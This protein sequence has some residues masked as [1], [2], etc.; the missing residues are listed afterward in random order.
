[1]SDARG[2]SFDA[3]RIVAALT[4]LLGHEWAFAKAG[5][6]PRLA[7][8]PVHTLAVMVFFS[9]SGFLIA[10]SWLRDDHLGRFLLR[11]ARRIFPALLV[12]VVLTV[13]VLGPAI[14]TLSPRA[15]FT[16]PTTW[17]YLGNAGLATSYRLPGVFAEPGR[18]SAAVNGSLWTLGL[19]FCCYLAVAAI[20]LATRR[21]GRPAS[22]AVWSVIAMLALAV[23]Q[24][25]GSHELASDGV[26]IAC[27]AFG[28]VA[29]YA[30]SVGYLPQI[31]VGLTAA[32]ILAARV[33][34]GPGTLIAC[35]AVPAT[36]IALGSRR[37][38]GFA[39]LIVA[40]D[41]SYGTYLY[42]F[43]VQQFFASSGH[44]PLS[45]QLVL[46]AC[47]TLAA[48]TLSWH[49]VERPVLHGRAPRDRDPSESVATRTEWATGV[50]RLG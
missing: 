40:G 34:D 11:R 6:A 16:T 33:D 41:V 49:L 20:G 4:V 46:A 9:I 12:V 28:A 5:A 50:N 38:P 24:L 44:T 13:F 8:I 10:S 23:A 37:I 14:T 35:A 1:M 27:F 15:Y 30:R 39:W 17:A 2:N 43:P 31:A 45:G 32:W 19:E 36:S 22:V 3:L 25:S 21:A 18:H 42:A 48:A 29:R 7:G 26:V 47:T